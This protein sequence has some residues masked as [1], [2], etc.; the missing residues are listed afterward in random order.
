VT[1]GE[2]LM[3]DRLPKSNIITGALHC[4]GTKFRGAAD[5]RARAAIQRAAEK[6]RPAMIE[7]RVSCACSV[8][9]TGC[10]P[11]RA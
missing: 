7:K 11:A 9:P 1:S 4:T 6:R 3:A 2:P 10:V 8:G 5:L